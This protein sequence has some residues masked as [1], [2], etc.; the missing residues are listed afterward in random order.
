MSQNPPANQTPTTAADPRGDVVYRHVFEHSAI[1][2]AIVAPDGR[3]LEVNAAL[4]RLLGYSREELTA[5]D[6]RDFTHP[7]DLAR[8]ELQIRRMLAGESEIHGLEK[9][10][11]SASGR[12]VW[13]RMD[14]ALVRR[15]DGSPDY[16][17]T[18]VRDITEQVRIQRA[19]EAN[20]AWLDS[21]LSS[22]ADGMLVQDA[23]G[24][25]QTC[26]RRAEVI[27]G[28]STEE[29][30]L[31]GPDDIRWQ[32]VRVDGSELPG[33][34]HP[35]IVALRHGRSVRDQILGMTGP[36]GRRIWLSVNSEP[37]RY[38]DDQPLRGVVTTFIDVTD[39]IQ[40]E[41][42]LKDREERLA[43]ALAGADLGMW[44]WD[45]N[46]GEFVFNQSANDMLGYARDD[47]EHRIEYIRDLFHADDVQAA[48]TAM[49]RHLNGSPMFETVSRLRCKSGDYI[50]VLIRGRVTEWSGNRAV[51]AC[52]TMMDITQ[53]KRLE[54]RLKLMADTDPLTG[55]AN[56]R[57]GMQK[58]EGLLNGRREGDS[59]VSLLLFDIDHFKQ[60]NDALGHDTGDEVL[61]KVCTAIGES[62]RAGDLLVRWGGEEFAVI[63]PGTPL[64]GAE[65]LAAKLLDVLRALEIDDVGPVTASFGVV[66]AGG[67]EASHDLLARVDKLMYRAKQ[68]G[69]NRYVSQGDPGASQ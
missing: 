6:F 11:L 46:T 31:R 5:H 37:L 18:Q 65:M 50:W 24:V 51:R 7:D 67:D 55:I 9:R 60:V 43:L 21:V 54:S 56:R 13:V 39:R 22:M 38:D 36:D 12:E 14:V 59:E 61:K 62:L 63:L 10:Y 53:W 19:L 8:N 48:R 49:R 3:W 30:R 4:C 41:Q 40:A 64:A 17:I 32:A 16:F 34:E 27:L 26:N 58:L 69:R 47:V 25:I 68:T 52:G 45:L 33:R 20:Q 1:G 57:C 23:Q 42:A 44:D 35:A 2:M 66:T 28:A 29:L 15:L